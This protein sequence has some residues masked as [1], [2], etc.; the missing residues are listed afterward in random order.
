MRAVMSI[1][2]NFLASPE[3]LGPSMVQSWL[4]ALVAQAKAWRQY[5]HE[6]ED[7]A[8]M[9]DRELADAGMSR[10]DVRA[11]RRARF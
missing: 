5:L 10:G 4:T 1:Q 11:F 8:C 9:G 7:L 2:E 3:S 6:M